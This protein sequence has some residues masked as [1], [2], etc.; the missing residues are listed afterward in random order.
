MKISK[1]GRTFESGKSLSTDIRRSIIDE[2]ILGGGNVVTGYFSGYYET[3]ATRFRVARSTVR[4]IWKQYCEGF[5]E[6]PQAKGGANRNREKITENDLELIEGLKVRRG[7][8]TLQEIC[9][10]LEAIGDLDGNISS[11]TICHII[12][13]KLPSGKRYSR[14]KVTRL[15]KQ[16]FTHA[17]MV[18]TQL[19]MV[20]T[21]IL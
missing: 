12:K 2:I 4:K 9:D 18:Y 1:R 6:E 16:R 5:S 19:Y 11:S 20:Y 10:E 3:V 15:T 7:S 8:V 14:K 13:N 17:N 21:H